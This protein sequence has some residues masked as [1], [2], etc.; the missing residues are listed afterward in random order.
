MTTAVEA[1]DK[2]RD[3]AESHERKC[4]VEVIGRHSDYLALYTAVASG[5]EFACIPEAPTDVPV[6]IQRIHELKAQ[7]KTSIIIVVAV[8]DEQ[9]GVEVLKGKFRAAQCPF[10]TRTLTRMTR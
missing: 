9:G 7:G 3:T 5:A 4:L 6:I 2:L 1:I 10:S 8:G